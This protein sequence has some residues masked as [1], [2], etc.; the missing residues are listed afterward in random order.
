M[1]TQNQ[2]LLKESQEFKFLF[3]KAN[4]L[5]QGK[6]FSYLK[7]EGVEFADLKDY[8]IGDDIRKIDWSISA[9][10]QKLTVKEFHEQKE[11]KHYI[12]L[13]TSA[14]M[15]L[16]DI[17]AKILAI[18]LLLSSFKLQD[19]FSLILT[20]KEKFK[21]FPLSKSKH[22]LFRFVYE[23]TNLNFESENNLEKSLLYL[24]QKL[25]H[26][27]QISIIT[28]SLDYKETELKYFSILGQ[29][30]KVLFFNLFNLEEFNLELGTQF[31]ED[32]ETGEEFVFDLSENEI[33]QIKQEFESTQKNVKKELLKRNFKIFQLGVSKEFLVNLKKANEVL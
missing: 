24:A 18:S 20:N 8:E 12:I 19:S 26:K 14:S 23:I 10:Q 1:T 4:S 29:K 16:K 32:I 5:L 33:E 31:Y 15:S 22:D 30:H 27:C 17:G 3:S 21:I 9:K 13:D 6:Y 11:S 2:D 25:T 28:D 7:G